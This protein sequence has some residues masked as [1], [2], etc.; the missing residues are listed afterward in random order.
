MTNSLG[1]HARSHD[2]DL[3]N[4]LDAVGPADMPSRPASRCAAGSPT[5]AS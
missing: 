2:A 4:K 1:D 3:G 5:T